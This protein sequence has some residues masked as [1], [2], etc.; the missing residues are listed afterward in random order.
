MFVYDCVMLK[1]VKFVTKLDWQWDLY[2]SEAQDVARHVVFNVYLID[3]PA[4]GKQY[5]YVSLVPLSVAL[6]V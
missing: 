5:Q 2:G 1:R 4:Y 6:L 3:D